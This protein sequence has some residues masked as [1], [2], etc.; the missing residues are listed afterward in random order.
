M[1]YRIPL[2]EKKYFNEYDRLIIKFN[3]MM[4]NVNE[5]EFI[6]Y[7]TKIKEQ[8]TE[9]KYI[10]QQIRPHFISNTNCAKQI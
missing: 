9:L 2:K 5:L 3:E 4:D 1:E 6:L 8:R 10:S 7:K